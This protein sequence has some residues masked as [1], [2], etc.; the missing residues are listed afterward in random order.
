M[1]A[2][3]ALLCAGYGLNVADAG[4]ASIAKHSPKENQ[5]AYFL[6]PPS[7]YGV[8]DGV[9]QGSA[10]REYAQMLARESNAFFSGGGGGGANWKHQARIALLLGTQKA[11]SLSG[12]STALLL[13]LDL[14]Q[15][16]LCTYG[17]GDCCAVV[18]R[19]N[20]GS[21]QVADVTGVNYHDNGA[22][23]QLAGGDWISDSVDDGDAETF[24]VAAGDVV[25]SFSD[26]VTGNLALNDVAKIVS[27]CAGQSAEATAQE[28]AEQA[29]A[30]GLVPD[31][32]TVVVVRLSEG[33]ASAAASTKSAQLP[34]G[35]GGYGSG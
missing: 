11:S 22:P 6:S 19:E 14:D 1:L 26:G 2:L 30:A 23:F 35:R 16:Q 8:F 12:M 34:P 24:N 10:S 28:I 4:A 9:S 3:P 25:V 32:I 20:S 13:R 31:D 15:Q 33:E 27:G 18:L 5:D 7:F 21:L 17:L 29:R